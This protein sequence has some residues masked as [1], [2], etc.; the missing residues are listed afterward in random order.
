MDNRVTSGY[1]RMIED[2]SEDIGEV[3]TNKDDLS[4]DS[5]R[6]DLYNSM[7]FLPQSE[8]DSLMEAISHKETTKEELKPI[9]EYDDEDISNFRIDGREKEIVAP[10]GIEIELMNCDRA[11]REEQD[12]SIMGKI[13]RTTESLHDIK[14]E[15]YK[16][17]DGKYREF[18]KKW[19]SEMHH[20]SLGEHAIIK[21]WFNG[22][23]ITTAK[24]LEKGV[25]GVSPTER[26]TRYFIEYAKR[27]PED[28]EGEK[29]YKILNELYVIHPM[30]DWKSGDAT[31]KAKNAYYHYLVTATNTFI[32]IKEHAQ[33]YIEKIMPNNKAKSKYLDIARQFL[34]S[35]SRTSVVITYNAVS[36]K[37]T[38]INL[39]RGTKVQRELAI[40]LLNLAVANYPSLFY[41]LELEKYFSYEKNVVLK[42]IYK[43]SGKSSQY[44]ED[45]GN[46]NPN[47]GFI[48]KDLTDEWLWKNFL[49]TITSRKPMFKVRN[50][51]VDENSNMDNCLSLMEMYK[52]EFVNNEN[53]FFRGLSYPVRVIAD[54]Q[55][56]YGTWRDIQRH[57]IS[58]NIYNDFNTPLLAMSKHRDFS[59]IEPEYMIPNIE[60]LD[61]KDEDKIIEE[62]YSGSRDAYESLKSSLDLYLSTRLKEM[63]D[64]YA[65]Y[66]KDFA[67]YLVEKYKDSNYT[68][69]SIH[70]VNNIT[71]VEISSDLNL[72]AYRMTAIMNL[73]LRA[74]K[75]IVENRIIP[76]GHNSYRLF[77]MSMFENT[78]HYVIPKMIEKKVLSF[79][80]KNRFIRVLFK[81]LF[82]KEYYRNIIDRIKNI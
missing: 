11:Q 20:S 74:I 29:L 72:L 16:S 26:S 45:I 17:N 76:A 73:D 6:D 68:E 19:Y 65:K 37:N 81:N 67:K 58:N 21:L 79:G 46:F 31:E 47:F 18:N 12:V 55:I 44:F 61:K 42:R 14:D 69:E 36:L 53:E 80:C 39:A 3:K 8:I 78:I 52:E 5:L 9:E 40:H 32:D 57:R 60:V 70:I 22:V 35:S 28:I 30:M 34:L 63:T 48:F 54:C 15:T 75:H 24:L 1:M 77:A 33:D 2:A 10:Y 62:I 13:S 59:V 56:D 43:Q 50:V 38:I 25:Y 4:M 41:G 49:P 71:M 64:L 7:E 66:L 51:F 82:E 27:V 23:D